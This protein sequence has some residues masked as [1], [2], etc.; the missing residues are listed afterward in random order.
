MSK[1]FDE[2][3]HLKVDVIYSIKADNLMPHDL[4]EALNHICSCDKCAELL[5]E[6]FT[7]EDLI[8]IPVGFQEETLSKI[9]TKKDKNKEFI[10]YSLRVAIAACISIFIVFSSSFNLLSSNFAALKIKAPDTTV[11]N[12]ISSKLNNFSQKII[13]ME[14]FDN[15]KEKR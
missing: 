3:G 9:K 11:V 15:E 14:V 4:E 1:I 12:S 13:T 2:K 5:A 10:F 6:S 8:D 7:K